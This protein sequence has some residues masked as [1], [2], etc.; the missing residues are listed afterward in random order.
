MGYN[1][2]VGEDLALQISSTRSA[3]SQW[4]KLLWLKMN[5][6]SSCTKSFKRCGTLK[7]I[8]KTKRTARLAIA[9]AG[10]IPRQAR[11]QALKAFT[12][13]K[14]KISLSSSNSR[15]LFWKKASPVQIASNSAMEKIFTSKIQSCFSNFKDLKTKWWDRFSSLT[16]SHRPK[17]TSGISCGL[18]ALASR[19]SMKD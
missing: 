1:A 9:L 8:A 15:I 10:F 2:K 12:T 17:V 16:T 18:P 14:T 11:P 5:A 19:T 13:N 4:S 7:K 3:P 6:K